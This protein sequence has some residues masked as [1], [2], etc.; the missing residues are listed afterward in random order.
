VII[1]VRFQ[2]RFEPPPRRLR[3]LLGV[4]FRWAGFIVRVSQDEGRPL[5][6]NEN[7]S[8]LGLVSIEGSAIL[9]LGGLS[10]TALKTLFQL[11]AFSRFY[12]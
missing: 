11:L 2:N 3:S 10:S 6:A 12:K 5:R 4:E 1:S 9:G 7:E 8:W